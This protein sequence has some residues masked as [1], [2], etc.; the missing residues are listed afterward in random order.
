[1]A[2]EDGNWIQDWDTGSNL[3]VNSDGSLNSQDHAGYKAAADQFYWVSYEYN[4]A[5]AGEKMAL[6]L[7]NPSG[8]G[9]AVRLVDL[10]ISLTNTVGSMAIIKVYAN[11]TVTANGTSQ[12]TRPGHV[13]ASQ[14]SSVALVTSGP[15][16][17]SNGALYTVEHVAG[18]TA[19]YSNTVDFTECLILEPNN[20]I[21][22]TG[23]PDGTNRNLALALTWVEI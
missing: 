9:K 8:S 5:N 18:G 16:V 17:S 10:T 1:M 19:G 13:G 3:K 22:I 2:R 6:L 7:R 21:L 14:S 15:T 4:L 11:P 20:S 12:T 23:N